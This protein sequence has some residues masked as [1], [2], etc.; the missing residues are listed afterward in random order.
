MLLIVAAV[1]IPLVMAPTVYVATGYSMGCN[2]LYFL[3]GT[4]VILTDRW[5]EEYKTRMNKD[6]KAYIYPATQVGDF[7]HL[8]PDFTVDGS[9]IKKWRYAS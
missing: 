3:S 8:K 5:G 9:Y 4:R 6:N 7:L 1:I 2:P